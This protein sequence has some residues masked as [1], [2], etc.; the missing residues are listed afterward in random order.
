MLFKQINQAEKFMSIR[1]VSVFVVLFIIQ[2]LGTALAFD[3]DNNKLSVSLI[4]QRSSKPLPAK[5]FLGVN[6]LYSIDNEAAWTQQ[7]LDKKLLQLG[8]TTLRYPGGEVA[9]NYDWETNSPEGLDYLKFLSHAKQINAN[10]LF[11]VVNVEGAFL[12][13][14]NKDEN[15]L[16]YAKKAARW[17]EE[18]KKHGYRVKYWEIGN[19][20][21][22]TG[23]SY[24]LTAE[25]YAQTL[26]IF[27]KEMKQVDPSI[28]IGVIGP[29]RIGMQGFLDG[30]TPEQQAYFRQTSERA[31]GKKVNTCQRQGKR[32]KECAQL[33][34]QSTPDET[35]TTK[36]PWWDAV[37]ANAK[38]SFDFA[39]I[40]SYELEDD[41]LKQSK[42]IKEIHAYINDNAG[43]NI[44]LDVTEWNIPPSKR[45]NINAEDIPLNTAVK[46]G[47]YLAAG[48]SHAIFWPMRYKDQDRRAL[49]TFDSFNLTSTYKTLALIAPLLQG[50][51][52][53]QVNLG[54]DVY[55]LQTQSNQEMVA[56]IVNRSQKA[57]LISVDSLNTASN[58]DIKQLDGLTGETTATFT[59]TKSSSNNV[60]FQLPPKSVTLAKIKI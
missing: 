19:E 9:D 13:T 59:K 46:L 6:N 2:G 39:V 56:M 10:D 37:L 55:F 12:S 38:N 17:V 5:N 51:F 3:S 30:L 36:T 27:Y 50:E 35:K 14:G 28:Q 52:V 22:L 32:G 21:Y 34:K 20:S 18:V 15:I 44:E 42:I 33:I 60:E 48:V 40:H 29:N 45:T 54:N 8:V 57:K 47:N 25:E 11:F 4:N 7:G 23:T 16:R 53:N 1:W 49:L 26:K 24:P 58:V 31:N 43:K 41:L